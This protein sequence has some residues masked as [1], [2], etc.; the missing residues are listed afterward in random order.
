MSQ[1]SMDG[2]MAANTSTRASVM[3]NVTQ[4]ICVIHRPP[5]GGRS[6]SCSYW[7]PTDTAMIDECGFGFLSGLEVLPSA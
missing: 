5:F 6:K 4:S 2:F 7:A 1:H 3:M